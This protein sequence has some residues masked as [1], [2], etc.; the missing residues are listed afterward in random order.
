MEKKKKKK[1]A[2]WIVLG[3]VAVLV[4]VAVSFLMAGQGE[5]LGME[6][7]DVPAQGI[8][9]GAYTGSFDG[10]RWSNTLQVTVSGGEITGIDIIKDQAAAKPEFAAELFAGVI[11]KQS[12]AVDTVSGATVSTKAYLKAVQN[13]LENAG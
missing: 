1:I 8:A 13:A 4:I 3:A 2:G 9:D 5:I 7:R 12:L 6:I 10:Y 11:E